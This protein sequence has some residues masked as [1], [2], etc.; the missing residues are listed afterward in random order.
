MA[1]G[2]NKVILVGNLGAD[3][4][5]RFTASGAAVTNL[6]LA[7][8]EVWR[9]KQTGEQNERTEWHR[10]V[11]FNKLAEV[12]GEFL[13]KGS[14]VYIEG[15]LQT[16]KWQDPSGQDRYSTEIVASEFQMLGGRS[17]MQQ[18]GG[19]YDEN[20]GNRG[21]YGNNQGGGYGGGGGNQYGNNQGGGYQGGGNQ[22]GNNQGGG[23][24]GGGYQGGNNQSGG[25]QGGGG[26]YGGGNQ[27]GGNYGGG[28]NYSGGNYG[29]SNYG[30]GNSSG[31]GQRG[32]G[33]N[34]GNNYGNQSQNASTGNEKESSSSTESVSGNTASKETDDFSDDDIPF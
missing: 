32:Y 23:Y 28:N 25:Y 34:S 4:E 6:R 20:R 1:R 22:Y 29:S 8:S 10:I 33:N 12:A 11:M 21:Q 15:K 30:G 9:D 16:R 18:G 19:Q 31:G 3:P 26:N 5:T 17:N 2:I 24:Q 14:Q 27:G 7:T 13:H